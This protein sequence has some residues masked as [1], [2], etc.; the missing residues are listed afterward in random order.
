MSKKECCP[1]FN[2]KIWNEK[3]FNWKDKLFIKEVMPTVFHIPFP[4]MI[5]K[6]MTKLWNL[7]DKSKKMLSKK[8]EILNSVLLNSSGDGIS[9]VATNLK[10]PSEGYIASLDPF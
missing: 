2:P 6:K 4:P 5:G 3:T 10:T 8:E 7:A 9:Y 1:K